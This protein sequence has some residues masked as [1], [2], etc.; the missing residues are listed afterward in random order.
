M[1]AHTYVPDPKR[2]EQNAWDHIEGS[3]AQ[4]AK[5]VDFAKAV[6]YAGFRKIIGAPAD[7]TGITPFGYRYA[8][9][10]NEMDA[11]E[12]IN[13]VDAGAQTHDYE[14]QDAASREDVIRA[15]EKFIAT[16]EGTGTVFGMAAGA[17]IRT[18]MA[19]ENQFGQ[20]YPPQEYLDNNAAT[21]LETT[22][23]E[24]PEAEPGENVDAELLARA[25]GV[26]FGWRT[27]MYGDTETPVD[28][29][30]DAL[31]QQTQAMQL[32][33]L[34]ATV[35]W[36]KGLTELQGASQRLADT[37]GPPDAVTT[38]QIVEQ[39]L[40]GTGF[41]GGTAQKLTRALA[42]MVSSAVV[43]P[44][45]AYVFSASLDEQWAYVA[46][47]A[48]SRKLALLFLKVCHARRRQGISYGEAL[49][50]V[51]GAK[52]RRPVNNAIDL[53][54]HFLTKAK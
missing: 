18:K 34:A 19:V 15:D 44:Q 28:D 43:V 47:L 46:L 7:G 39:I 50:K 12:P 20:I 52:P 33:A 9:P 23:P 11:G 53:M 3:R 48:V 49:T 4:T 54:A 35:V 24:L 17:A 31:D 29:T 10:F 8:G 6:S 13:E 30:G 26:A 2:F 36:G 42:S 40:S 45:Q 25:I 32:A 22:Y 27:L 38:D 37:V 51:T 16:V 5:N 41:Y 14:Y 21:A 1:N